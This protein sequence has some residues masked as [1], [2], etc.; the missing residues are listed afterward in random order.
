[1]AGEECQKKHR[2]GPVLGGVVPPDVRIS[3]KPSGGARDQRSALHEFGH[4]MHDAFTEERRFELAKLGNRTSAEAFA[5]L[6]ESLT[7]EPAWL[8]QAGLSADASRTWIQGVAVQ[9]LFLV[10]RAAGNGLF[11]GACAAPRAGP[12]AA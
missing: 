6:M 1:L 8:E 12:R 7:I 10:R 5:A 3:L 9:E 11:N 2:R 4:A